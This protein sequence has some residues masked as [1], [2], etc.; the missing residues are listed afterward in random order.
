[1]CQIEELGL[2]LYS[3]NDLKLLLRQCSALRR[4]RLGGG[5][6]KQFTDGDLARAF[7]GGHEVFPS[8]QAVQVMAQGRIDKAALAAI[9]SACP[10]LQTLRFTDCER[11]LEE[12]GQGTHAWAELELDGGGGGVEGPIVVVEDLE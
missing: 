11:L 9:A 6:S 3:P 1:L 2:D 10:S 5:W 12:V 7:G 4:L 8:L